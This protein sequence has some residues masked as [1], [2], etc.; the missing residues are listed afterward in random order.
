MWL[1][2]ANQM[3]QPAKQTGSWEG[4]R[5]SSEDSFCGRVLMVVLAIVSLCLC[6]FH[7]LVSQCMCVCSVAHSCPTLCDPMDCS[8]PGASV[9]GILQAGILEWVAMPSSSGSSWLRNWTCTSRVSCIAGRFFTAQPPGKP[10]VSQTPWKFY[11]LLNIL[12]TDLFPE[13]IFQRQVPLLATKNSGWFR[14]GED[15]RVIQ[16]FGHWSVWR[17]SPGCLCYIYTA[18]GERWSHFT[19]EA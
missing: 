11:E 16:G 19:N 3:C 4:N 18:L 17:Q 5:G 1:D 6:L 10:L 9:P 7:E 15:I 8:P 13:R 14:L 2:L 12:S